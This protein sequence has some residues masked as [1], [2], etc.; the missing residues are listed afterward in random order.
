MAGGDDKEAPAR[1][2][3]PC[4][5]TSWILAEP[6]EEGRCQQEWA[7]HLSPAQVFI[8]SGVWLIR[9]IRCAW[10]QGGIPGRCLEQMLPELVGRTGVDPATSPVQPPP[11]PR[12]TPTTAQ[13]E[14]C[15]DLVTR[16]G[17]YHLFGHVKCGPWELRWTTLS[18]DTERGGGYLTPAT[19]SG[20]LQLHRQ[21]WQSPLC[22][23]STAW[24]IYVGCCILLVSSFTESQNH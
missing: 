24:S 1:A 14:Q 17:M 16:C 11:G 2:Q 3:P 20:Q 10:R 4:P 15:R 5:R 6:P 23:S 9:T 18:S 22:P 7:G 8:N 19:L 13:G 12:R 21:V